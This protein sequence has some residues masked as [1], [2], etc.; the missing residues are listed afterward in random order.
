MSV[1]ETLGWYLEET[2]S[3]LAG[4]QKHHKMLLLIA[5]LFIPC[6]SEDWGVN[7]LVNLSATLASQIPNCWMCYEQPTSGSDISDWI[8]IYPISLSE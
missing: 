5:L 8:Y 2:F 1:T 4:T 6:T 7:L 3:S